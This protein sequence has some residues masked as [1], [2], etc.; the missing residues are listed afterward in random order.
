MG[1]LP[2]RPAVGRGWEGSAGAC[3][4]MSLP[5]GQRH[6][7]FVSCY[8]HLYMPSTLYPEVTFSMR[9]PPYLALHPRIPLLPHLFSE[10]S[11]PSDA[12]IF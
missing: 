2:P 11:S 1:L 5:G 9:G 8:D 4:E 10:P 7:Y 12:L 3:S 6:P